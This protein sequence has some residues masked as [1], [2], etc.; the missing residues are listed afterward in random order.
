MNIDFILKSEV[1]ILKY[2]KVIWLSMFSLFTAMFAFGRFN[3]I[4]C[5]DNSFYLCNKSNMTIKNVSVSNEGSDALNYGMTE[6]SIEPHDDALLVFDDINTADNESY[7]LSITLSS[8][9]VLSYNS[10]NINEV[11]KVTVQ[12]DLKLLYQ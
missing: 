6:L 4:K 8:G 10:L 12:P 5:S 9:D 3:Y 11:S 1:F 2:R 7:K